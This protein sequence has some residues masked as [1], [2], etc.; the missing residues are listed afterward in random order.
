HRMRADP[1]RQQQIPRRP[2]GAP[3]RPLP[4]DAQLVAVARAGRDA[5]GDLVPTVL[6]AQPELGAFDR[7]EEVHDD[8]A[9]QVGAPH[10]AAART[11]AS[12]EIAEDVADSADVAEQVFEAHL[13]APTCA[14]AGAGAR[15]PVGARPLGV[16]PFAQPFLPELVVE[17]ALVRVDQRLVRAV[18][19]LEARLD[20]LVTGVLVRMELGRELP[21]RLLDLVGRR[22]PG[23]PE[24][25]VE[26]GRHANA[27]R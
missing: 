10:G 24:L 13:T 22:R 16:E 3:R 4:R 14:R 25:F 15:T 27:S 19:G 26:I 20:L 1:H 8:L 5:H 2:A 21:V 9:L 23:Y 6:E 17:L 7:R 11:T 12:Q 18:D